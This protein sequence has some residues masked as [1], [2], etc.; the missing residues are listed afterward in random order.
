[1]TNYVQ[2]QRH[3]DYGRGKAAQRLGPPFDV[4]RLN[5][6]S[7][8]DFITPANLIRSG[9][10]VFRR[11]SKDDKTLETP[12]RQGTHW[13]ELVADMTGLLVGDVFV[14]RDPVYGVG[15]TSITEPTDQFNG[16]ALASHAPVRKT[17]GGRLDREV[18]VYRA[19]SS[20]GQRDGYWHNAL[21]SM[22]PL[23]LIEGEYRLAAPGAQ[24]S[25]VPTGFMVY[26]R[27]YGHDQYPPQVQGITK[28]TLWFAYVPP[29]PGWAFRE[30]DRLVEPPF[31]SQPGARYVVANPYSQDTGQVGSQLVIE[32]E[33]GSAA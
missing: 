5:A 29:L 14:Q 13:Y 28:P 30:G 2:I 18:F 20:P 8:G 1:M 4:Y 26:Y 22:Q 25:K 6:R 10:P 19:S 21:D 23:V 7:A 15:A 11:S 12:M 17:M 24:P 33:V 16:F 9:F 32:R 27:Q 31:N 3:I